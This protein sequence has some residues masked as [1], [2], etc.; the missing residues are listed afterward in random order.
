MGL[1]Y[2]NWRSAAVLV[3]TNASFP[4]S[5]GLILTGKLQDTTKWSVWVAK[6]ACSYSEGFFGITA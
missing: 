6:D 4:S 2:S 3:K 5:Q 1:L